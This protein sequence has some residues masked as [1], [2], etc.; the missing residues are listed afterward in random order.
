MVSGRECKA[1]RCHVPPGV[2]GR[3]HVRAQVAVQQLVRRR[4]AQNAQL[5]ESSLAATTGEVLR[6]RLRERLREGTSDDELCATRRGHR[7]QLFTTRHR[8]V[9]YSALCTDVKIFIH[10]KW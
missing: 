10:H 6:R 2:W 5:H 1:Y 4:P 9:V 7:Q 8:H 3:R